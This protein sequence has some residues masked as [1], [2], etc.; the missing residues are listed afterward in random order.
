MVPLK[1]SI[2]LQA[3]WWLGQ[4]VR[5][6]AGLSQCFHLLTR[7]LCSPSSGLLAAWPVV[8]YDAYEAWKK[9]NGGGGGEAV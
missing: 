1:D 7:I 4:Y 5:S 3:P 9:L 2:A 6:Q 8:A